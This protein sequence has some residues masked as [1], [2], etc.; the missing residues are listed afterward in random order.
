LSN[1]YREVS[2]PNLIQIKQIPSK[3]NHEC[4]NI[5]L[6]SAVSNKPSK[7]LLW[8]S[9]KDKHSGQVLRCEVQL[10]KI[11]K[12]KVQTHLRQFNLNDFEHLQLVA[13]DEQ[14]NLFSGLDGFWFD[15]HIESGAENVRFSKFS[16]AAQAHSSYRQEISEMQSD[17]LFLKGVKQGSSI[18]TAQINEVGYEEVPIARVT[19][20]VTEAFVIEP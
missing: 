7:S 19:V 15:W 3:F 12:L 6:V 8:V 13:Y 5:A 10:G 4:A 2:H 11:A 18:I 9:A 1:Q 14:G 16:E 17:V 20:T